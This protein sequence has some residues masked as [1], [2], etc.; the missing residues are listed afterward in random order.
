MDAL[1]EALGA[2]L[3]V[4]GSPV[5]P[6]PEGVCV[7]EFHWAGRVQG[8]GFS[9]SPVK[10]EPVKQKHSGFTRKTLLLFCETFNPSTICQSYG[11][12]WASRNKANKLV[13]N[14]ML[15]LKVCQLRPNCIAIRSDSRIFS[16]PSVDVL[17]SCL[18]SWI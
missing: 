10:F 8:C 15:L 2:V 9:G 16:V 5:T 11:T 6:P 1:C 7:A 4:L 13:G 18:S 14:I 17:F 3:T 12:G